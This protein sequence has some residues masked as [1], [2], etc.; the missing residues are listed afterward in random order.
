[1]KKWTKTNKKES[2]TNQNKKKR[3]TERKKRRNGSGREIDDERDELRRGV[4]IACLIIL[5]I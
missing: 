3:K 1:M 2:Y 4:G 5:A